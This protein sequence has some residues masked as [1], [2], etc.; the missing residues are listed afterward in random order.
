MTYAGWGV[1]M[2]GS[3]ARV[4]SDALLLLLLLLVGVLSGGPM[5][6][7]AVAADLFQ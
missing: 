1:G 5:D 6:A 2:V 3:K 7:A 4:S